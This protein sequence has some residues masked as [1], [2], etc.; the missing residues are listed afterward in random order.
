[1]ESLGSVLMY[2]NKW[3]LPQQGVWTATKKQKFQENN[4]EKDHH[5]Y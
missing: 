3:S 2:F 5:T 4:W 1:M